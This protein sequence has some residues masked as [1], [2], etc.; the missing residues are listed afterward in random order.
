MS[1][2]TSPAYGEDI[3][4]PTQ[5]KNGERTRGDTKQ[6]GGVNRW[7]PRVS[8]VNE[9]AVSLCR[10]RRIEQEHSRGDGRNDCQHANGKSGTPEL[11]YSTTAKHRGQ[12]R[13]PS[14]PYRPGE[15]GSPCYVD[16]GE[17]RAVW[18]RGMN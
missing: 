13:K 6:H 10:T 12:Q 15:A 11:F 5:T 7:I 9:D 4:S 1:S 16:T 2:R 18:G 3:Q 14:N 17:N 8:Q